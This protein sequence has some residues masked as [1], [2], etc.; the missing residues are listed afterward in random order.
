LLALVARYQASGARE[1][2]T[3]HSTFLARDGKGKAPIERPRLFP[4]G[5]SPSGGGVWFGYANPDFVLLI[6]EGLESTLS[7]MRLHG[8]Q[9]GCAALSALGIERLVLP[10]E[11]RRVRVFC[12]HDEL[13]Q[14]FA[15]AAIA[16]R[17]WRAEGREVAM[18]QAATPGWDANDVLVSRLTSKPDE[19]A[20]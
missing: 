7:A 3:V 14:G 16:A 15:A 2:I 4:A 9:A 18:S 11:A 17:R 8:A 12:D 20:P 6:G 10:P 5:T 19:A 1:P 13:Q